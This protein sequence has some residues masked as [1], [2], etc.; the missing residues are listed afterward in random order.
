MMASTN[1]KQLQTKRARFMKLSKEA[2]TWAENQSRQIE[3]TFVG[4]VSDR[5]VTCRVT[6]PNISQPS[7]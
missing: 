3:M 4:D 5:G 1:L 2:E 6:S 7:D